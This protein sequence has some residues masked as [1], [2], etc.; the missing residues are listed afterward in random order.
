MDVRA[1]SDNLCRARGASISFRAAEVI[2]KAIFAGKL[3]P[4]DPLPES[5][6][7]QDLGVSQTSVREALFSLEREGLVVRIPNRGSS[8]VRLTDEEL[9]ERAGV[10]A[11]LESAAAVE[12]A[13]KMSKADLEQMERCALGGDENPQHDSPRSFREADLE[14]HRLLWRCSGSSVLFTTLESVASPM[15]ALA[16]LRAGSGGKHRVGFGHQA[17]IEALRSGDKDQIVQAISEHVNRSFLS[18]EPG[19]FTVL[20]LMLTP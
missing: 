8:V 6:L 1:T 11:L 4:G 18:A 5:E 16:R 10:Y 14:F 9:R 7:T 2:R 20:R 3:Q 19:G 17:I 13:D 15:F 12:A